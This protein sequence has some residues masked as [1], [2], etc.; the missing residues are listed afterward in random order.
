MTRSGPER[1]VNWY[2]IL[3]GLVGVGVWQVVE[4]LW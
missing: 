2:L 4:W 1:R 3:A